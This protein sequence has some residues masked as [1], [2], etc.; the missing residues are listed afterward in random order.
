MAILEREEHM[1]LA[2]IIKKLSPLVY[3]KVVYYIDFHGRDE[4]MTRINDC[5]DCEV[6]TISTEEDGTLVVTIRYT[7][8]T[9]K[10]CV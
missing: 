2:D 9:V 4:D 10:E 5:I 7:G 6:E 8:V 1:R 3:L